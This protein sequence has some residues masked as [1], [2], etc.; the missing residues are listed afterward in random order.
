MM[1]SSHKSVP[2]DDTFGAQL[3]IL[4]GDG[5]ERLRRAG[6]HLVGAGRVGSAV[7]QFLASA[8]VG[9]LSSNDHQAVEPDNLNSL[10]FSCADVGSK[11]V[12]VLTRRMALHEHSRFHWIALPVEADQ[13]DA[14]VA[15]GEQPIDAELLGS[16]V[17]VQRDIEI[18]KAAAGANRGDASVLFKSHA[19]E[20]QPVQRGR[21][22]HSGSLLSSVRA[23]TGVAQ[24]GFAA[25]SGRPLPMCELSQAPRIA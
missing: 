25:F 4:G 18:G 8:G 17:G 11:K 5:Q 22:N 21:G 2:Y 10:A 6:V 16:A 15:I 14:D 19:L 23:R 3:P 20:G 12:K 13:V 24:P 9:A 7:A 1:R